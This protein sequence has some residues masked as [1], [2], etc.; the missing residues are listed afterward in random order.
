MIDFVEFPIVTD[1]FYYQRIALVVAVREPIIVAVS[2]SGIVTGNPTLSEAFIV[3]KAVSG[4]LTV[5]KSSIIA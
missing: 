2:V 5:S 4:I 3:P 1:P